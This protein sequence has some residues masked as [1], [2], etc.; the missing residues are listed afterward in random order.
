MNIKKKLL[1]L[2]PKITSRVISAMIALFVTVAVFK[3]ASLISGGK[4][5]D[6]NRPSDTSAP[7]NTDDKETSIDPEKTDDIINIDNVL[8]ITYGV[9]GESGVLYNIDK[10]EI[11]SEKNMGFRLSC[12]DI[13]DITVAIIIADMIERGELCE[14]DTVVCPAMAAKR[15]NYALSSEV[16]SVGERLDVITLLKCLLYQR[17]SSYAYALAVHSL[18]SEDAF[19]AEM[20]RAVSEIGA[21]STLFTNVCGHDDGEAKTTAYDTAVILKAFFE[22]DILRGIFESNEPV[23]IRKNGY[24]SSVYLTVTNDFFELNCT[25]NQAREDGIIG[26][27]SGSSG[28]RGW[29][30]ILFDDGAYRYLS[31]ILSSA[32]AFSDSMLIYTS[33]GGDALG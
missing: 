11:V 15:P 26:G 18:G 3:C 16:Y 8:S 13:S 17:G 27:R 33:R 31:I 5:A 10:N 19:V 7:E 24:N 12:G 29:C 6:L 30:I 14:T 22:R 28:Y 21:S 2:P 25:E 4:K 32:S 1:E 9:V 23:V 20:N